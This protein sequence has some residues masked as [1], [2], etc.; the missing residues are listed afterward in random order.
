[1]RR[2]LLLL[3][4]CGTLGAAAG[5]GTWAAFSATTSRAS[6]TFG[7]GTVTLTADD[8]ATPIYS[9]TARAPG[10]SGSRCVRVAYGG[11]LPATVRLYR[12]ALADG[13]GLA[14]YV[15][16]T[17]ERGTG[18]QADCADFTP[19]ATLFASTLADFPSTHADGLALTNA[20]GAGGWAQG[21]AVTYRVTAQL[22]NDTAAQG[23]ATGT[24]SF[25]WEARNQ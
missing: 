25:T 19:A 13:T 22:R 20:G 17:V 24:H 14:A 5:Y 1:M 23:L 18:S 10:D 6:N 2:L 7:G 11:S 8:P 3:I 9:L 4:L 21:D 16:L 12:S 15:D